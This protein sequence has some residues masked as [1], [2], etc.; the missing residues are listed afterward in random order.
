M[1]KVPY[2]SGRCH[3]R[4]S[5]GC[6]AAHA[7]HAPDSSRMDNGRARATPT[8]SG[9]ENRRY[10]HAYVQA[11]PARTFNEAIPKAGNGRPSVSSPSPGTSN[12]QP[13]ARAGVTAGGFYTWLE[14]IRTTSSKDVSP[15]ANFRTAASRSVRMPAL[16]APL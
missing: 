2:V 9:K 4:G 12:D 3:G 5:T 16:L 15:C 1:Q 13:S 11:A 7:A 6:L 14:V 8:K 10:A